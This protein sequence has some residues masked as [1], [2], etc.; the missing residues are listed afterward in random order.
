MANKVTSYSL[1][2]KYTQEGWKM[3]NLKVNSSQSRILFKCRKLGLLQEHCTEQAAKKNI[4]RKGT[5]K[6]VGK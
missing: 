6:I 4:V 5:S 3:V 2:K 1:S